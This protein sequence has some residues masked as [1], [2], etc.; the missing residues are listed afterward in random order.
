MHPMRES[1][2]VKIELLITVKVRFDLFKN[3]SKTI[4]NILCIQ[5]WLL[6]HTITLNFIAFVKYNCDIV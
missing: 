5:F 6:N 2:L 4:I 1:Y 3:Y